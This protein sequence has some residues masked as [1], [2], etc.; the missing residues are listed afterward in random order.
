MSKLEL[1]SNQDGS[2]SVRLD[3]QE[4][5]DAILAISI[6]AAY[7]D[8]AARVRLDLPIVEGTFLSEDAS[9]HI[10]PATADLLVRLGWT[11][12]NQGGAT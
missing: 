10:P 12:P 1:R 5:S 4:I 11:P 8:H 6:D 7:G 9:V 2:W 3:G